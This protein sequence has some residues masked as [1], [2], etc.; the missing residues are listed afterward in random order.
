MTD[1]PTASLYNP[2]YVTLNISPKV[3]IS[4]PHRNGPWP[5][6]LRSDRTGYRDPPPPSLRCDV[7][8]AT[9]S[10]CPE[11]IAQ[12]SEVVDCWATM[13]RAVEAS[14]SSLAESGAEG[15]FVYVGAFPY[16]SHGDSALVYECQKCFALVQYWSGD[17]HNAAMH[18]SR[19]LAADE[20]ENETKGSHGR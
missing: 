7:S 8:D 15:S 2:V 18:A 20:T 17:Q 13:Y 5:L 3:H 1:S 16:D 12:W 9:E 14:A 19:G 4:D 6:C 11:C 10:T